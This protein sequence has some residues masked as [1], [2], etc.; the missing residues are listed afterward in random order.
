M[1]NAGRKKSHPVWDFFKDLHGTGG[2]I[3]LHCNWRGDDRSPNNLK[4]HLKR[5][6]EHDGIYRQFAA[7]LAARKIIQR[8]GKIGS[9]F[10]GI[11][12]LSNTPCEILASKLFAKFSSA[13][14]K[15]IWRQYKFCELFT[16]NYELIYSYKID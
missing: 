14:H 2:V 13:K 8:K 9:R 1:R 10:E 4:T 3:C 6:H 11:L 12:L 16:Q 15:K 7:K 5:Y